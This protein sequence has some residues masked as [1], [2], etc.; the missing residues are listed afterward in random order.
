[1]AATKVTP[2]LFSGGWFIQIIKDIF[3]EEPDYVGKF[4]SMGD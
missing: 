3:P 1:L 4:F 2:N